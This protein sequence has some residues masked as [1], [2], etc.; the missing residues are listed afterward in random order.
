MYAIV[1][2]E[3]TGGFAGGNRMTEIAIVVHDGTNVVEE[4]STLLNP[5]QVIPRYISG[6]TG[7][8][9]QMVATA[10]AFSE[11]AEEVYGLLNG[12]IF[13]AHNVQFDYSFVKKALEDEGL[14]LSTKR[15]CTVRLS[16]KAFPGL[17]SYSLG[18]LC[19]S[20]RIPITNRHRAMG[21]A[22]ATAVL[23]DRII[24][25]HEDIVQ[26]MLKRNSKEDILPP[27]LPKE[28]FDKL[29][30]ACGVYYFFDKN[31]KVIYVGKA[32]NI[33]KRIL[34]HF[35]GTAKGRRNQYIRNEIHRVEYTPTGNELIALVLEAQEIK[36]LWPKYNEAIKRPDI[37]WA[38]YQYEDQ[39]GYFRI[40][41][42]KRNKALT[43]L[44]TFQSHADAWQTLISK[45]KE[46]DLC[47]KLSGV[48]KSNG[49]CY[50]RRI[51]ECLGACE[52]AE[53]PEIYN[54]RALEM[55]GSFSVQEDS[56]ALVGPGRKFGEQSVLLVEEGTYSGFGFT[57][58]INEESIRAAVDP[59]PASSEIMHYIYS[60]IHHPEQEL[61]FLSSASS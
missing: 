15:L 58:N 10:P 13:I 6:L 33:R 25:Q 12:R 19:E 7:I 16:R 48:Q 57:H 37:R 22:R 17:R 45:V 11:V 47:P 52:H 2:I 9:D 4:Y 14:S 8:T 30:E 54:K 42:G 49:P 1:D 27:N 39:D 31:G 46:F 21:D 41:I 56:F 53:S 50:D 23:F 5:Q 51:G 43:P 38:I 44:A 60:F 26:Q 20:L 55:I 36:R 59:A 3:T 29:P 24:Q 35:G 28:E 18:N 34:G 40:Q 61:I 32:V